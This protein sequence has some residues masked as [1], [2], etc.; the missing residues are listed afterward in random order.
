ME[1]YAL[2][3][4]WIPYSVEPMEFVYHVQ[5]PT[6]LKILWFQ[7]SYIFGI[8]LSYHGFHMF[9]TMQGS[10]VLTFEDKI[11]QNNSIPDKVIWYSIIIIPW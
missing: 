9:Y 2:I 5:T 11:I 6:L 8:Y 7:F 1:N 4:S 10:L 3:S